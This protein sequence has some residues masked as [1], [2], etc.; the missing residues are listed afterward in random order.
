MFDSYAGKQK[1]RIMAAITESLAK[2]QTMEDVIVAHLTA[3]KTPAQTRMD[4]DLATKLAQ[5]LLAAVR[6]SPESCLRF[7]KFYGIGKSD[8]QC[9]IELSD[10][11]TRVKLLGGLDQETGPY[12]V[13]EFD[14]DEVAMERVEIRNIRAKLNIIIERQ[15]ILRKLSIAPAEGEEEYV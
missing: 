9:D 8:P 15:E 12:I 1:F 13:S 10:G 5:R 3:I 2:A 14:Q 6:A 4:P 7:I 11:I